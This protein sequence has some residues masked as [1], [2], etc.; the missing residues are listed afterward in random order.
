MV[1]PLLL[2]EPGP[3]D[4]SCTIWTL[5]VFSALSTFRRVGHPVS[6]HS[7]RYRSFDRFRSSDF[8]QSCDCF[9]PFDLLRSFDRLQLSGFLRS[10][11]RFQSFDLLRPFGRSVLP[12]IPTLRL[13]GFCLTGDL[14]YY[15]KVRLSKPE[16]TYLEWF[17][18]HKYQ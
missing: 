8:L 18:K 5:S 13:V 11:D 7:V 16:K 3:G 14:N 15:R 4:A 1:R 9:G 6:S 2:A 10:Y 12:A 17:S